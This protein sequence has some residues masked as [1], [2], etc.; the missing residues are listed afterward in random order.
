MSGH[1]RGA[2]ARIV[3]A[4]ASRARLLQAKAVAAPA[5]GW[6]ELGFVAGQLTFTHRSF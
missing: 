2:I 4:A 1:L 3:Q 5:R 6:E